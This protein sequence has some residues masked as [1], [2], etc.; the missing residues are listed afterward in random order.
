MLKALQALP[1][2]ELREE[3]ICPLLRK[4][5]ARYVEDTHGADETG[6]DVLCLF[7]DPWGDEELVAVQIKNRPFNM[8]Q[9]SPCSVLQTLDQLKAC[10]ETE[11]IHPRTAQRCRPNRVWLMSA[12]AFRQTHLK[13]CDRPLREINERGAKFILGDKLAARIQ[14]LMPERII[15]LTSQKDRLAAKLVR[16][17]ASVPELRAF[18]F[19]QARTLAQFY[20]GVEIAPAHS[21]LLAYLHGRYRPHVLMLLVPDAELPEFRSSVRK[22]DP[23]FPLRV[24]PVDK[25][26]QDYDGSV[27]KQVE[28]DLPTY[29]ATAARKLS[30]LICQ[31]AKQGARRAQRLD[32]LLSTAV[33]VGRATRILLRACARMR[34]PERPS[35]LAQRQPSTPYVVDCLSP[36]ELLAIRNHVLLVG[37]PGSGKTCYAKTT[38]IR[39][40]QEGHQCVFFPCSLF[41]PARGAL[42]ENCASYLAA[43]GWAISARQL[44]LSLKQG[45][46]LWVID[47]LDEAGTSQRQIEEHILALVS[48]CRNVR[49]LATC[50]ENYPSLLTARFYVSTVS[51]LN[52]SQLR[53][54]YANWFPEHPETVE[55]IASF[56]EANPQVKSVVRLPLVATILAALKQAERDLPK[57]K[58]D[59]YRARFELLLEKWERV[60]A[61]HRTAFDAH[62]KLQLL[63]KLAFRCHMRGVSN[64]TVQT[65][66]ELANKYWPHDPR[67]PPSADLLNEFVRVNGVL[68]R[69]CPGVF[70]FGHISYQEYLA[71]LELRD[72]GLVDVVAGHFVEPSWREVVLFY[73]AMVGDI[74]KLLQLVQSRWGLHGDPQFFTELGDLATWT[75]PGLLDFLS[76]WVR[77]GGRELQDDLA[78]PYDEPT[79]EGPDDI[80]GLA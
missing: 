61:R 80:D 7:P 31:C 62:R 59:L 72:Q 19:L 78:E 68:E 65:F 42:I 25:T 37:A 30:R 15:E 5:G 13:A 18:D 75:D 14:E 8:Q 2:R 46:W 24:V 48:K 35:F 36:A 60:K 41:D 73:A 3:Y 67:R 57:S 11:V 44:R 71:A 20:V 47:G 12:H 28:L 17:L 9:G 39:A 23:S 38:A 10:L 6:K 70:S 55:E 1:E 16:S 29:Y 21:L 53:Q 77:S 33:R 52:D 54:L 34:P 64:F 69:V 45:R 40:L 66:A 27:A 4:M 43:S 74:T 49:V 50:R 22:A 32:S 51:Q 63:Q 56:L 26:A 58:V 76:E 79:G